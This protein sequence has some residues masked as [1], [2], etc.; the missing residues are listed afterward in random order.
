M[1]T[2]ILTE[3]EIMSGGTLGKKIIK[4]KKINK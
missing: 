3:V 4:S 2:Y 1:T